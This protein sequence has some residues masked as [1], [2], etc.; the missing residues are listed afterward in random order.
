[1]PTTSRQV[2]VA[3]RVEV[4]G[5]RFLLELDPHWEMTEILVSR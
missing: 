4:G 2:L 3:A 5:D 1:M